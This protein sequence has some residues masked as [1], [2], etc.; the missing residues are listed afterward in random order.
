MVLQATTKF[1]AAGAASARRQM[2]RIALVGGGV[3]AIGILAPVVPILVGTLAALAAGLYAWVPELRTLLQPV[4]RVPVA[5]RATRHAWLAT[6]AIA[7]IFLVVVGSFGATTRSQ[8]KSEWEAERRRTESAAADAKRMYERALEELQRG[9]VGGAEL[10]L[11]EARELEHAPRELANQIEELYD[12]VHR[13]GNAEHVLEV[14][15]AL[16]PAEFDAF[17][18]SDTVPAALEFP[19]RVLTLRAVGL[20]RGQLERARS[21]R[22][23]ANAPRTAESTPIGAEQG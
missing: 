21:L 22:E 18:G 17:A 11:M 13:S 16:P 23:R 14:L 4:V 12:R 1:V 6:Y 5:A 10:T 15:V 8:V 7:G 2:G 3:L 9:Q 19:E 20:G